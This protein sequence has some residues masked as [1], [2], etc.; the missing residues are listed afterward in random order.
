MKKLILFSVALLGLGFASCKK[1]SS[2]STGTARVTVKLTDAPGAYDAVILSVKQVVIHSSG[3]E[4]TVDV[5]GTPIDILRFRNGKDTLLAGVDVPAGRLQEV[6]LVLNNTGNRV[7][8]NGVSYDLNTPSGQTSGV[9]LKVQDD[10][11]SGIAYTLL[12]DFDAAQSIV[13]TGNGKYNLKPV[14]RAIP[15]AVSG[16]LTGV[17]TPVAAF[18]RVY[19]IMGTDTVGTVADATGKFYFPG[20]AAGTYRVNFA[21]VTPYA[22]KTIDNVTVVNGSVKDLG[23]ITISQ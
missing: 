7:V 16:A 3:G 18:P 20:L 17:V 13:T 8:I 19:A 5:N 22:V 1:D 21:P 6:R 9:K 14:I 10:L 15:A 12:L 4:K 23:G 11:T 2:T